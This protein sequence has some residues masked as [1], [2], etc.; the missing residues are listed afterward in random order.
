MWFPELCAA[1]GITY[2][3]PQHQDVVAVSPSLAYYDP[4]SPASQD[5]V[6]A[7][8]GSTSCKSN[9]VSFFSQQML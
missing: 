9:P 2:Q 4:A 3:G 8:L 7:T 5:E 6:K 1:M